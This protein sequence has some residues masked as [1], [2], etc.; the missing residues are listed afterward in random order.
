VRRRHALYVA[1]M[2]TSSA[3]GL[4]KG[5]A[6]AKVLDPREFGYYGLVA[7]V[8]Q[9][10]LFLSNWGLL[11][12][13]NNHL[14][15]AFGRGRRDTV[16]LLDRSL[17]AL[18]ATSVM[19]GVLYLAV[20]TA[21]SPGNRDVQIAL[22]LAAL[23]T[24]VS[25]VTEFHVLVLRV[26]QRIL[27][28]AAMYLLRAVLAIVLG[29]VAGSV[30][31][32]GGVIGAELA[33]LLVVLVTARAVWLERIVLARPEAEVVKRLLRA[34]APL[35]LSN[36][37]V[38]LALTTDRIFVASALPDDFGQYAFASLVVTGW[39]AING[40]LEQAVAPRL[41][42]DYG[43]GTRL[44]EIRRQALR[45]AGAL[46]AAGLAGLAALL[47][48]K[49]PAQNGFLSEYATGL[50]A[51][52]VLWLGGILMLLAFPGFILHAIKPSYSL[53]ASGLAA[54]VAI[55]GG[56][57]LASGSPSVQDFAWLFVAAQG[58]ALVTIH[59]AVGIETRRDRVSPD[60]FQTSEG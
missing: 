34:G 48:I 27:P 31:G 30:W 41:L 12:A 54:A 9:F 36:V 44:A 37:I 56:S 58:T 11:N 59:V 6:Y 2:A 14:P 51:M 52:P 53:T 23:V 43:A 60:L 8:L 47:A 46:A 18:I 29:T 25:T 10:G 20:V 49:G 57:V 19:T 1:L 13:L 45:I 42:Y 35:M 33:A 22:S 15:I 16:D 26:E 50:D 40:M 32:Y 28:M 17:T 39:V 24:L 4:V 5:L 3:L 38:A 7:L 21:L 55:G